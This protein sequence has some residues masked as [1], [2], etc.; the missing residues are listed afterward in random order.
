MKNTMEI[1]V[2]KLEVEMKNFKEVNTNEHETIF[3]KLDCI[4]DKLNELFVTKDEFTPVKN[5][6]YG[7]VG[8]VLT[9]VA[10]ALIRLIIIQ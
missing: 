8:L 10:G 3:K 2:A 4:D 1:K 6:V 9:A 7:M 5:V